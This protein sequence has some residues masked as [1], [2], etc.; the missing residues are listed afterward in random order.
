MSQSNHRGIADCARAVRQSID[1]WLNGFHRLDSSQSFGGATAYKW[2]AVGQQFEQQGHSVRPL[3]DS[4][5]KCGLA[6]ELGR[7]VAGQ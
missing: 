5:Q 7:F 1:Q 2:V 6:A 4:E 3:A